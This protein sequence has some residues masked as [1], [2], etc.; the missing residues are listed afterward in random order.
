[1]SVDNF[2]KPFEKTVS[3]FDEAREVIHSVFD[4]WSAARTFAW[5][6]QVDATWPLHS[7]L[8]RR[9]MWTKGIPPD[10]QALYEE[11]GSILTQVHRWGL[12]RGK[13]GRLSALTQLAV[14]QHYGAPTRLLDIT[15][16]PYIALW[17]AV[18]QRWLN[19]RLQ[20]EDV[21]A[22]VF[23]IDVTDRLI[24]END[25]LRP[26]E[27]DH[28][29]P[30]RPDHLAAD[31]WG[32]AVYAWRPPRIEDRISAQHGGFLMGGVPR[33][34]IRGKPNQWP[35]TTSPSAGKWKIAETRHATCLP[36]RVH[37]LDPVAGGVAS[38]AVYTIRIRASAKKQIRDRLEK[39]FGYTHAQIYPDYS[40]FASFGT[41]RLRNSP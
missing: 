16:N 2:W 15:F 3:T 13:Q 32:A 11:E 7:S 27:D 37:K 21:D 5:R 36:L 14:L 22:R 39:L 34:S 18:E 31:D 33:A 38:D 25:D 28:Q 19:G 41:P 12:H 40:G 8:Y 30:W 6:G 1:M 20:L 26:W 35:K 4:T 9:L 17:F 23:A 24:N 29:R 10:E